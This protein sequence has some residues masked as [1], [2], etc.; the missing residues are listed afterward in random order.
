MASAFLSGRIQFVDA[1]GFQRAMLARENE[2]WAGLAH[3]PTLGAIEEGK[4]L[5][6]LALVFAT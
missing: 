2:V 6:I 4:A 5:H 3:L 1:F